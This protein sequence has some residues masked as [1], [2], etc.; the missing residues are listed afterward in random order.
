MSEWLDAVVASDGG[1]AAPP[2]RRNVVDRYRLW[3]TEAVAADLAARAR[4]FAAAM[5]QFQGD[6]NFGTVV[7]NANAFAASGVFYVGRRR[8][9]RRGAVGTHHYT[10]VRHL[11]DVAALVE[12]A[13]SEGW[14]LVGFDNVPGAVDLREFVWPDRPLMLFGEESSGLTAEALEACEAV[15]MIPQFGSVRSLNAGTA[16]G[17]A[18]YDW[19]LRHPEFEAL[20]RPT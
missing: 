10:S 20:D 9:D 6:F 16:S 7:R 5:E 19:T 11:P 2:V 4:P 12:V 17:I 8:W 15:V 3:E 13:R 14:T 1:D 18:M